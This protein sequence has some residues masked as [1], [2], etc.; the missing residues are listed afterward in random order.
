[1]TRHSFF[2]TNSFPTNKSISL[3]IINLKSSYDSTQHNF[4]YDRSITTSTYQAFDYPQQIDKKINNSPFFDDMGNRSCKNICTDFICT[5]NLKIYVYP[6][7][8]SANL[9]KLVIPNFD[10]QLDTEN[11]SPF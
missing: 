5:I 10:N 8:F 11:L 2:R 4:N 7:N 3:I 6:V 1:M 9:N